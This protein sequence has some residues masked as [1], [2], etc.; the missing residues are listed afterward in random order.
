MGQEPYPGCCQRT[1]TLNLHERDTESSERRESLA[2]F[3]SHLFT[4]VP[5]KDANFHAD[6][7]TLEVPHD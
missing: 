1:E 6:L 7:A 2:S 5:F 4:K 3:S